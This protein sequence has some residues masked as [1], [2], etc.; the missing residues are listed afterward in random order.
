MSALVGL[1]WLDLEFATALSGE[2]D[3]DGEEHLENAWVAGM[4]YRPLD[5]L[6]MAARFEAFDDDRSGDQDEVI[7]WRYQVGFN[8]QLP[9]DLMLSL[10]YRHTDFEREGGSDAASH[11]N[12]INI[13]LS[14]ELK[15]PKGEYRPDAATDCRRR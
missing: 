5:W 12:E 4:P 15:M 3:Q 10:E 6:E 13:R 8:W 14:L 9:E 2:E 11:L 7:D 1:F